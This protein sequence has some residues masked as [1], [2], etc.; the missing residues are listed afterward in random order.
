MKKLTNFE[1]ALKVC[2]ATMGILAGPGSAQEQAWEI[3]RRAAVGAQ[4]ATV[5]AVPSA[6]QQLQANI[7]AWRQVLCAAGRNGFSQKGF[8][9]LVD[10]M[11]EA[12]TSAV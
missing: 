11:R 2:D 1:K 6:A 5:A 9:Q 12:E 10:E 3:V 4:P 7:S 8:D